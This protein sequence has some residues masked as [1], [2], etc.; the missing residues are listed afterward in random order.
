MDHQKDVSNKTGNEIK[1]INEDRNYSFLL[2]PNTNP[3]TYASNENSA[4]ISNT[5]DINCALRIPYRN[6]IVG[7]L[8]SQMLLQLIANILLGGLKCVPSELHSCIYDCYSATTISAST[9]SSLTGNESF[10][11][12]NT[13]AFWASIW[14]IIRHS[15]FS[16][17]WPPCR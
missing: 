4:T 12:C 3:F 9:S 13:N 14:S 16:G 10:S 5:C 7:L 2:Y 6:L 8:A 15:A 1:I 11:A 17:T